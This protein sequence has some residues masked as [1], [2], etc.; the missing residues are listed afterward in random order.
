MKQF[1]YQPK[2]AFKRGLESSF[3]DAATIGR[4]KDNLEFLFEVDYKRQEGVDYINQH[5]FVRYV[6]TGDEWYNHWIA[7]VEYLE[8]NFSDIK[9][10]EASQRYHHTINNYFS[11]NIGAAQRLAEPYGYDPIEEWYTSQGFPNT[12]GY[13]AGTFTQLALDEGYEIINSLHP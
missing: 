5:H 12:T 3:S 1:G 8:D 11:V 4:W 10:F 2:E 7:K 13:T 9:Y 6:S